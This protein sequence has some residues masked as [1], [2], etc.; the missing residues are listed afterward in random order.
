[1]KVANWNLNQTDYNYKI[2]TSFSNL[3][4]NIEK[5]VVTYTIIFYAC[6]PRWSCIFQ[7]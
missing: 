3:Q 4:K 1:M 5:R 2:I 6:F 7:L